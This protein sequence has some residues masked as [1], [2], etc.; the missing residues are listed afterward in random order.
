M[1]GIHEL[2]RSLTSL[3]VRAVHEKTVSENDSARTKSNVQTLKAKIA[4]TWPLS[5]E[6]NNSNKN[7]KIK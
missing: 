4:S 5:E 1:E 6:E 2:G 3:Q 7:K